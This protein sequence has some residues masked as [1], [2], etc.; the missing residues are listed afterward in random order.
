MLVARYS[1]VAHRTAALLG[2]GQDA[3]DVVQEAFVKAFRHLATFRREAAF[4]PWLLRIVANETHTMTRSRG[5]RAELLL[6][7]GAEPDPR[8][9]D[10]PEGEAIATDRRAR[11]LAAVRELPETERQAV[12]CRYFLQLSEAETA[13]VLGWPLGSVKSRT[14]RGLARLRKEVDGDLS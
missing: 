14:F 2:A 9:P 1:A 13:E 12:V 11:L 5:R 4:R 8:V 10:D 7:A 3:E 6:R